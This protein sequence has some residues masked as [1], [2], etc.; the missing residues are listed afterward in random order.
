MAQAAEVRNLEPT[1]YNVVAISSW[2][3]ITISKT[4]ENIT[5]PTVIHKDTMPVWIKWKERSMPSE[6]T[7][8]NEL[9]L[10]TTISELSKEQKRQITDH[11]EFLET[12][13]VTTVTRLAE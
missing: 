12:T 5:R 11:L 1:D 8:A 13:L 7:L 3:V 2:E 4:Q 9:D 6:T 10:D